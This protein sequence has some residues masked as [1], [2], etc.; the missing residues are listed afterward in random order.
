VRFSP[1]PPAF[2]GQEEKRR[3]VFP[4]ERHDE[5][6]AARHTRVRVEHHPVA[7]TDLCRKAARGA[8]LPETE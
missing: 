8:W 1:V 2:E 3:P 7:P 5:L 4:P 6:R